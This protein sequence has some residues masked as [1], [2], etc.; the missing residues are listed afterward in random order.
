LK[1]KFSDEITLCPHCY[2]MS[3]TMNET[4]LCGKCKKPKLY[5]KC[6]NCREVFTT[7]KEGMA[8]FKEVEHEWGGLAFIIIKRKLDGK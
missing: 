5:F 8:H 7:K 3:Y 4:G 6:T 1:K 2:S